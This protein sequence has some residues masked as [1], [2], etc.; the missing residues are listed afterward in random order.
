[1][2]EA[3]LSRS[4][5]GAAVFIGGMDGILAEYSMFK[6]FH[7][8]AE[9]FAVPGSGGAARDLAKTLGTSDTELQNLDFSRF[10]HVA[11]HISPNAPRNETT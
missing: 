11:L 6:T 7:P 4:D 9:I 3:M 1:M 2:R 5:L 8:N 10:F